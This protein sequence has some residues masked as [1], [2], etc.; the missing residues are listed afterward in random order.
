MT[1]VERPQIMM[2]AP[3]NLRV[4]ALTQRRRDDSHVNRIASSY[5]ESL[6]GL[7]EVS[8]RAD[9]YYVIDGQHRAAAAIKAGHGDRPLPCHVVE[10]LSIP[11]EARRFVGINSTPKRPNAVEVFKKRVTAED[12]AAV[13][14][15]Q[16]VEAAGLKIGI[17]GHD[18]CV[19]AVGAL[20]TV[21]AGKVGRRRGGPNP[22]LLID[23]LAV[24]GG[25]WGATRDAYDATLIKAVGTVLD[26]HT[27]KLDRERLCHLLAKSGT[28]AQTIG[29]AKSLAD[30][31]RQSVV[32]AAAQV[33]V[34]IYNHNLRAGRLTKESS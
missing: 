30:A 22:D 5:D 34:D 21:Y 12:P 26:R 11:E 16:I 25:A 33:M 27:E 23:T 20:E 6:V 10:G 4:D 19:T 32:L 29:R 9:G 18:G 24:L 15:G 1:N 3:I 7:L 28:A 14:I 8:H 31:T 2:I 13:E 17:T